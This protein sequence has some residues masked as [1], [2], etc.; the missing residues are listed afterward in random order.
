MQSIEGGQPHTGGPG[1]DAREHGKTGPPQN[2]VVDYVVGIGSSAG[3]LESLQVVVRGLPKGLPVAY[4]VA[5]H[6]APQHRSL[7]AEL[8][9]RESELEVL[10]AEDGRLLEPGRIYVTPPNADI[11]VRGGHMQLHQ[12][13]P[14]HGP[15][16]SIDGLFLSLAKEWGPRSA[17]VLLSGTGN[18]GSYGMREV[19]ASGGLTM[20]QEPGSAKYESMPLAAIHA[21]VAGL[22]VEPAEVGR[23]VERLCDRSARAEE[24]PSSVP[25]TVLRQVV[26]ELLTSA[27]VDFSEY[28]E[29]TIRRQIARRMSVLQLPE[30]SDYLTYLKSNPPE[31]RILR[32]ALLVSVTS[33][34][35]DPAVWESLQRELTKRWAEAPPDRA[36]RV[37][38]PGCATGE[39]V[40]TVGMVLSEV[41]GRPADL[42]RR[43]KIFGTDLDE[44]SLDFA[45]RGH[46]PQQALAGLPE[47]WQRRYFSPAGTT[48]E[49]HQDLREIS[50][51]AKHNIAVDPAFVRLDMVSFR[52][53]LIYFENSLQDRVLQSL[54]H[55]LRP[56]GL[57][58][59]GSSEGVTGAEE[60]F[61]PVLAK[62]RVFERLPGP[63]IPTGRAAS[64][65]PALWHPKRNR[66]QDEGDQLRESLL[67]SLS[68]ST[69]V[70]NESDHVVQIIGDVSDF[71]QLPS[72]E[73]TSGLQSMLRPEI[74]P[75]VRTL[76]IQVRAA[77]APRRS[78]PLRVLGGSAR[79]T[80][81]PV[82]SPLGSFVALSFALDPVDPEAPPETV[83]TQ[84]R[85]EVARLKRELRSTQQALQA[86]IE[87]LETSNEELQATNEELVASAEEL[88]ASNEE[89]ETT[90]EELQATNEELGTL[91]QELQVRGHE[92]GLANEDLINIQEALSQAIVIVDPRLRVT[93]YSALAVRLFGLVEADIGRP[94]TTVPTSVRIPALGETLTEVIET[95]QRRTIE[96]AGDIASHLLHI[97]PYR[98]VEGSVKG[99][100]M[101]ITDIS[102]A[103]EERRAMEASLAD[104]RAMTD[105]LDV[106]VWRRQTETGEVTFVNR[107]VLDLFGLDA[108]AA[109]A[110]P[111]AMDR[112][113]DPDDL[114]RI[115]S[116]ASAERPRVLHYSTEVGGR[117]HHLEDVL[118]R[119]M[120]RP[121]GTEVSVG[122]I[123]ELPGQLTDDEGSQAAA[124]RAI[125][126]LPGQLVMLLD[127]SGRVL[128]AGDSAGELLGISAADLTGRSWASVIHEL[129]VGVASRSLA[130]ALES[131]DRA[132]GD[133]GVE[134]QPRVRLLDRGG[135]VRWAS[136]TV[137]GLPREFEDEPAAAVSFVDIN[138]QHVAEQD[139]TRRARYD[140]TTGLLNRSATIDALG[141]ELQRQSRREGHTAVMW[142]DL[143]GFKEVNDRYGHGAGDAVLRE[144]AERLQR[145]VRR[146]D[147]VGRL[148]GDEF[149]AILTDSEH[150]EGIESTASRVLAEISAPIS[151]RDQTLEVSASIGIALAPTDGSTATDVLHAADT[152]MY[153]AKKSGRSRYSYFHE[154][155]NTEAAHR[156]ETRQALARALRNRDFVP[157]Y[158]PILDL[159]TGQ[160]WGVEALCRW[161]R[162]DAI[163]PAAQFIALAEETGQIRGIGQLITQRAIAD[164]PEIKRAFGDSCR[165]TLN[166]SPTELQDGGMMDSL[167]ST[168]QQ[169]TTD[170]LVVEVT[171]RSLL[172]PDSPGASTIRSLARIGVALAIDDFGTGFSNLSALH[173]IRPTLIKADSGF[174]EF[175][176]G[177]DERG[178][179]LLTVTRLLADSV[180][181]VTL[182]EGISG[183]GQ[184]RAAIDHGMQ[185]GQGYGLGEPM[186]LSELLA[187][188]PDIDRLREG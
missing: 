13:L 85:G 6:V 17:A 36:I 18:D 89:L 117:T 99:A 179:T 169:T 60:W 68:P 22:V 28:K 57:L 7:M 105:G 12:P 188:R 108:A 70:I 141:T 172:R 110:D 37:W 16:P 79:V 10:P 154:S 31:A 145:A 92:L 158:Q 86:T 187:W 166:L 14:G 147:I 137:A 106:V 63:S 135:G 19:Q 152:A 24:S 163:I 51:F 83:T 184:L 180:C 23:A 177:G 139:L 103:A 181:A 91:N 9:D 71:A 151:W 126:A 52:N 178:G 132:S 162:D 55:A 54:H 84:D 130:A 129:D 174:V 186:P 160:V 5:Q 159:A 100:I 107:S 134:F 149:A 157:Y 50:V 59:L 153:A 101:S 121:D 21:G 32:Q 95:G 167:L 102:A 94:L 87:E 133:R 175:A 143:D 53:V 39:E 76:I 3:G 115:G 114:A 42:T 64:F 49:V 58:V 116:L 120:K 26:A 33:F 185:L 43:V 4:I 140:F 127:G 173:Q 122:S 11:A 77:A 183:P 73:F 30:E 65:A 15:K 90:N 62:H 29:G 74:Y 20:A 66:R 8:L 148:G 161:V 131:T 98:G 25:T 111:T 47:E 75:E 168:L 78:E 164:L 171:E 34:Y 46:Y 88:Q 123:R 156:A 56:D 69:I 113:L 1:G 124:L 35:R 125:L 72:G 93:R 82:V 128:L 27:G 61:R 67:K 176:S 2:A 155:L 81:T 146:Q 97:V 119:V 104:M 48:V 40:Y 170:N 118:H 44:S 142:L 138:D 38:V 136:L 96:V 41:L 45:R 109:M 150:P 182:A 165:L 144:V 80:G 112:H